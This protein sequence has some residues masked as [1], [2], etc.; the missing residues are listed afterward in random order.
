[1]NNYIFTKCLHPRGI[2]NPYIREWVSVPCGH[3]KACLLDKSYRYRQLTTLESLGYGCTYFVTLTYAN[4]YIPKCYPIYDEEYD[5][6][7][8]VDV[9]S[10]EIFC[11]VPVSEYTDEL[12]Y[13]FH[14]DYIPYLNKVDI[15]LFI[16]R[17]R[18]EYDKNQNKLRYFAVGEYGP[19]HFRP[20][21]H[22]LLW[23]ECPTSC[24]ELEK[25][26][27]EKWSFGRIDV[28]KAKGDASQYVAGYANSFSLVPN[29]FKAFNKA[30]PFCIHS[31]KLG[32][33]NI[34]Y[35]TEELLFNE[36]STVGSLC[37]CH[38]GRTEEYALFRSYILRY[39]PRC[40]GLSYKDSYICFTKYTI[41]LYAGKEFG[42][43]SIYDLAEQIFYYVN[44][45][46]H[47][48][49]IRDQHRVVYDLFSTYFP[50]PNLYL[51][52]TRKPMVEKI[53]NKIYRDLLISKKF[54]HLAEDIDFDDG[55]SVFSSFSSRYSALYYYVV[56]FYKDRELRILNNY[57]SKLESF[58]KEYEN[59][60]KDY[61]LFDV[62]YNQ[63]YEEKVINTPVF[64][65]FNSEID[66]NFNRSIKH[67]LQNDLN[68]L[69]LNK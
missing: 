8:L 46:N 33:K 41:Y 1:M 10:G 43:T 53:I 55:C 4:E 64:N 34:P 69:L 25:I 51:H 3:C 21:Y 27:S 38:D 12:V 68:N 23:F 40:S 45:A 11:S 5:C 32:E 9:D 59:Y 66:D 29:L 22:L 17:L 56:K 26:I 37:V 15:Q 28:Q 58:S 24:K 31:I 19:K 62:I 52:Y 7:S 18:K 6:Y 20:H 67:K 50:N 60:I 63:K 48:P 2:F 30:K 65:I 36:Y 49:T 39:V 35:S 42:Y 57:Y 61:N 44:R 13:K 47:D 16:K 54:C 14:S